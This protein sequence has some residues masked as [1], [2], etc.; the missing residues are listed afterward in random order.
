MKAV[1]MK[2][3]ST[4]SI[5][6]ISQWA[7]FWEYFM[8]WSTCFSSLDYI[9]GWKMQFS[10]MC[11]RRL[12]KKCNPCDHILF[13]LFF[14]FLQHNLTCRNL[15]HTPRWVHI[16]TRPSLFIMDENPKLDLFTLPWPDLYEDMHQIPPGELC[17]TCQLTP[18][19]LTS[20]IIWRSSCM[21]LY[22]WL[23]IS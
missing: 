8:W 22:L 13:P 20:L 11:S 2:R 6:E 1:E 16:S 4:D 3:P 18:N 7:S 17:L 14:F 5:V 23:L 15:M 19:T 12:L 10:S 9:T 21:P